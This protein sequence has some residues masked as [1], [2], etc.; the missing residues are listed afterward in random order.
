VPGTDSATGGDPAADSVTDSGPADPTSGSA[1]AYGPLIQADRYV[2]E[3]SR[4]FTDAVSFLESAA[5]LDVSLGTSL[6]GCFEDRDVIAGE[7][8]AELATDFGTEF[9]DYFEPRYP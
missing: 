1:G 9:R 3:R 8:V 4:E 2:V 7:A 6:T 5:M